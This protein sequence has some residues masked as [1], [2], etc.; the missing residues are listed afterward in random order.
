[1]G[2]DKDNKKVCLLFLLRVFCA[3]WRRWFHSRSRFLRAAFLIFRAL[4][5]ALSPSS[6]TGGGGGGSGGR[7]GGGGG[8]G[9]G[10]G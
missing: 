1:M 10:R 7:G 8:G 3:R 2:K 6:Y 5:F 9:G 4:P